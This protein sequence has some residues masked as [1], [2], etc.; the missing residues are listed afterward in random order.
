MPEPSPRRDDLAISARP[1]WASV[2]SPDDLGRFLARRR[3]DLALTQEEVAARIGVNRRY[4]HEIEGGKDIL[5]Y[6][7]LFALLRTL[8]LDLQGKT[9]GGAATPGRGEYADD[10]RLG[11]TLAELLGEIDPDEY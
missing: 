2:R 3:R 1:E 10:D 9:S 6:R 8:G 7:R 4:V 5:A 11:P